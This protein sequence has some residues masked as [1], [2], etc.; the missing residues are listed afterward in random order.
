MLIAGLAES[1]ARVSP[2]E[3]DELTTLLA[4]IG[5]PAAALTALSAIAAD[6]PG[7]PQNRRNPSSGDDA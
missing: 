6:S 1:N 5:Q 7:L 4:A 3:H 2:A